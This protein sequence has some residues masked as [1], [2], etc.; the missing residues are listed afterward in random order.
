MIMN[1]RCG[2]LSAPAGQEA[3]DDRQ[4]GAHYLRNVGSVRAK[5]VEVVAAAGAYRYPVVPVS[6]VRCASVIPGNGDVVAASSSAMRA[7]L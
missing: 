1:R 2:N 7:S 3:A 5:S 4:V 6:E